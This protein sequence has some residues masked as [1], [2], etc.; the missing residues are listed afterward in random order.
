MERNSSLRLD[1][2]PDGTPRLAEDLPVRRRQMRSFEDLEGITGEDRDAVAL[3]LF[4]QHRLENM[5]HAQVIGDELGLVMTPRARPVGIHL[6][7]GYDVRIE[8]IDDPRDPFRTD[9]PVDA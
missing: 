1:L 4:L 3:F 8:V 7:H 2:E 6:L 5:A 9:L